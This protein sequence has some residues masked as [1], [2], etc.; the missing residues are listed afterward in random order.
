LAAP[1]LPPILAALGEL[2]CFA[3]WDCTT[4]LRTLPLSES[5]WQVMEER[6]ERRLKIEEQRERKKENF[7]KIEKKREFR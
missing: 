1:A 4:R 3:P 6:E 7:D 2:L 5:I